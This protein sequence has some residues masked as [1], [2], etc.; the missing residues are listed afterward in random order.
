MQIE[1]FKIFCDLVETASFSKAAEL[2]AITQSAVSQQIRALEKKFKV[3]LIERGKKHFSVTTEGR[4]FLNASKEILRAYDSLSDRLQELQSVVAGELLIATVYSIGLHELPRNLKQFRKAYPSVDVKVEYLRSAQVYQRVSE[5]GADLGLVAFPVRR[6]GLSLD[7]LWK[8]KLVLICPPTHR[9]AR[10][11][12]VSINALDRERF[13]SFAFDQPTRKA[14]DR[15]FKTNKVTIR[16]SMEF[17]NIETV[18]RAVEIEDGISIVPSAT[19]EE[20]C[21]LG[22]LVA[23]EIESIDMWRPIG[24]IQRR[25]RN[26]NSASRAFVAM[27]KRKPVL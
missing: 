17:D 15:I 26:H 20:E 13:I 19:V 2:N 27:L 16:R 3:P 12:S 11:R 10:R 4:A 22:S 7:N 9:L 18:K 5:G 1:T 23:V 6:R 21:Q 24:V 14:I 25:S 8:D